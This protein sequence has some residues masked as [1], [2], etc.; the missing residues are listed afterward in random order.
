MYR[1]TLSEDNYNKL[2]EKHRV[3]ED[4]Y[5]LDEQIESNVEDYMDQE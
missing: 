1:V 4:N 2:E 5:D 3:R